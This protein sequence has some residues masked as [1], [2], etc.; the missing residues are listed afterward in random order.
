M[1]QKRVTVGHEDLL[2]CVRSRQ[3][4]HNTRRS[5]Y[6]VKSVPE[7]PTCRD[8]TASRRI[9][10]VLNGV[11]AVVCDARSDEGVV[12]VIAFPQHTAQECLLWSPRHIG[13]DLM[14]QFVQLSDQNHVALIV[15]CR[16]AFS[17]NP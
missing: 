7:S 11:P 14:P 6:C 4:P 17:G 3:A 16:P 10:A 5:S 2:V 12:N 9:R 15:E 8:S 13:Q 1:S